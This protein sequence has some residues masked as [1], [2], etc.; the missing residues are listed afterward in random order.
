LQYNDIVPH[1]WGNAAMTDRA[2]TVGHLIRQWA[3]SLER[4]PFSAKPE[5]ELSNYYTSDAV[6]LEKEE[7]REEPPPIDAAELDALYSGDEDREKVDEHGNEVGVERDYEAEFNEE[8]GHIIREWFLENFEPPAPNSTY[9][10]YIWGGPFYA[11]EVIEGIFED[12]LEDDHELTELIVR[13]IEETSPVWVIIGSRF[14]RSLKLKEP[15]SIEEAYDRVQESARALAELLKQIPESPAGI[16]HNFPPE[17]ID[18]SPLETRDR[19]ELKVAIEIIQSQPMSPVD[20]GVAARE[21]AVVIETK[22]KKVQSWLARQGETF[23]T[24]AVKEAGKQFGKW[25]PRALWLFLIE[26]MFAVTD[27]V[28]HWLRIAFGG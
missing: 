25:A 6:D 17:P 21:A 24:E 27:N 3:N 19:D 16:G 5:R 10:E 7:E 18:D 12:Y 13:R 20:N 15:E 11:R 1:G 28:T 8:V 23:A 2:S 4:S 22:G 14:E 26:R 9:D